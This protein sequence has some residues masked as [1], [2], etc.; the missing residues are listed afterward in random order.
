[1]AVW[2]YVEKVLLVF[3]SNQAVVANPLGLT[4]PFKVALVLETED[5]AEV[6]TPGAATP[7]EVVK[8]RIDPL[9]VFTPF[10]ATAL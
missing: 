6:I 3:H 7:K 2:V 1:L 4:L 9:T 5:T 10:A 8:L